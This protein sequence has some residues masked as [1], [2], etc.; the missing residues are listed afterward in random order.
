MICDPICHY[1]Y[2]QATNMPFTGEVSNDFYSVVLI[3]INGE[4]YVAF[5]LEGISMY[6]S[7]VS[8]TSVFHEFYQAS[9]ND[10]CPGSLIDEVLDYCRV[11][12]PITMLP[13]VKNSC[14]KII[15]FDDVKM[16]NVCLN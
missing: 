4:I 1:V 3:E 13:T 10:V 15:N 16:F 9:K 14:E 7:D 8:I 11:A 6:I 2:V 5:I 12:I